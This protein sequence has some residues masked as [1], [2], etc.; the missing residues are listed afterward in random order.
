[1]TV[2]APVKIISVEPEYIYTALSVQGYIYTRNMRSGADPTEVM[3]MSTASNFNVTLVLGTR[4]AWDTNYNRIRVVIPSGL[5][6]GFYDLK[7][8][9]PDGCVAILHN[10]YLVGPGAS[11]IDLS[12]YPNGITS[13]A[14][15]APITFDALSTGVPFV[16]A[17]RIYFSQAESVAIEV[18]GFS[19][20]TSELVAN[21]PS[22]SK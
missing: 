6:P 19:F 4:P 16:S 15:P 7:L 2:R 20:T 17:P 11:N 14:A 10:A 18:T 9:N 8:T 21:A 13:G 12:V 3:L 5:A 1:V 22:I